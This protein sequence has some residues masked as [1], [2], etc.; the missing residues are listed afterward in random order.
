ME[1]L[2]LESCP[3]GGLYRLTERTLLEIH[4]RV[5]RVLASVAALVICVRLVS[6]WYS[7]TASLAGALRSAA[8]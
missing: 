6:Q 5:S 7:L 2:S 8:A 1:E 4:S 3:L